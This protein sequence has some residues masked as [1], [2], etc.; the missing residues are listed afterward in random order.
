MATAA[1]VTRR[2]TKG[3]LLLW[4]GVLGGPAAW[5]VALVAGYSLEE[6]FACSPATTT[7]GVILGIGVRTLAY[8][9]PLGMTGFAVLAGVTSFACLR[10]IPA[11]PLDHV[12]QRA[13]W[14]AWAGIFNSVLYALAIITSVAG[15]LFLDVCATTP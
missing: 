8:A 6:W 15:P 3:S 2:E 13:R 12:T 9:I 11:E 10:R 1:E 7:E 14:M 5:A 4:F